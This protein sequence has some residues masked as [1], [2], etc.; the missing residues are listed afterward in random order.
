MLKLEQLE[1]LWATEKSL[2]IQQRAQNSEAAAPVLKHEEHDLIID[3]HHPTIE[4][5]EAKTVERKPISKKE[6]QRIRKLHRMEL[7]ADRMIKHFQRQEIN[8]ERNIRKGNPNAGADGSD[9]I[10]DL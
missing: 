7:K 4:T 3:T 8:Q 2:V 1:R 5:Q 10:K 6:H 9:Y